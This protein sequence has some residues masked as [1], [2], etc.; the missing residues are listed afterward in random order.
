MVR[1]APA[2]LSFSISP[3]QKSNG[4]GLIK[5]G[6]YP[7]PL[8]LSKLRSYIGVSP[9]SGIGVGSI[10]IR[11]PWSAPKATNPFILSSTP[12]NAF[13][14]WGSLAAHA[15]RATKVFKC[16]LIAFPEAGVNSLGNFAIISI[17]R[18][19]YSSDQLGFVKKLSLSE[20]DKGIFGC[21]PNTIGLSGM[22]FPKK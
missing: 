10:A 9:N 15:S 14:Q 16:K 17:P 1:L 3:L 20:P 12:S 13:S 2:S 7:P 4:Q 11:T 6:Q 8:L 18:L 19:T 5:S 21:I 22:G